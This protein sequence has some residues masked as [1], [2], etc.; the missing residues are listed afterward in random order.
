MM[1]SNHNGMRRVKWHKLTVTIVWIVNIVDRSKHPNEPNVLNEHNEI[2][3][4]G[5]VVRQAAL[6]LSTPLPL[7]EW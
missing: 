5:P 1:G 7:G 4:F 3:V 6:E 2:N